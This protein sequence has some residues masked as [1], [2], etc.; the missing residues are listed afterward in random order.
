MAR[1]MQSRVIKIA[2]AYDRD[3]YRIR[4]D[5]PADVVSA[6]AVA[7]IAGGTVETMRVRRRALLRGTLRLPT[8][9]ATCKGR[10]RP[11]LMG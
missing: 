10:G 9:S 7:R 2:V 4:L 8:M 3:G 1:K 6:R 11:G 5:D